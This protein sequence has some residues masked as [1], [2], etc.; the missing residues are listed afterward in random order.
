MTHIW[1]WSCHKDLNYE[2]L[3]PQSPTLVTLLSLHVYV[4]MK[5]II[6]HLQP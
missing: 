4:H 1:L 2:P 3:S 6:L 5:K